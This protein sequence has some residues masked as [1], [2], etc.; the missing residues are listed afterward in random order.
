LLLR[1]LPVAGGKSYSSH[2]KKERI[3]REF[4]LGEIVRTLL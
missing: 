4:H 2:H 1:G 3:I